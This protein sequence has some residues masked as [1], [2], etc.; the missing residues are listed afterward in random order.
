MIDFL[1]NQIRTNNSTIDNEISN[2]NTM[3]VTRPDPPIVMSNSKQFA[4]HDSVFNAWVQIRFGI[5]IENNEIK[6]Y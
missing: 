5:K 4:I 3:N 2:D 1:Q 6:F